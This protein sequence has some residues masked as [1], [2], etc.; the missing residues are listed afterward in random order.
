MDKLLPCVFILLFFHLVARAQSRADWWF[1]GNSATLHFTAGGPESMG[2]GLASMR[3]SA[4]ISDPNGNYLLFTHGGIVRNGTFG[5][6]QNGSFL[7][8][9][10]NNSQSSLFVPHPAS[11]S[12]YF[13]FTVD[14]ANILH[15]S[16]ADITANAG[17]AA[18]LTD[19]FNIP[20][21]PDT[22]ADKITGYSKANGVDY[23][24]VTHVRDSRDFHVYSVTGSGVDP[25]PTV[26]T[27][28][29]V[30]SSDWIS[31]C[32]KVSP[33]GKR[34]AMA[35]AAQDSIDL[36]R[37]D[38]TT[39]GIVYDFSIPLDG[40]DSL[41][42]P[43]GVEFS[44]DGTFLYATTVENIVMQYDLLAGSPQAVINSG[45]EIAQ[46][47]QA[48]LLGG[49]QIAPDE[50][51]YISRYVSFYLPAIEHPSLP[52][53]QAGF[54]PES[55]LCVEM[56]MWGMP[57]FIQSFFVPHIQ[58][59]DACFG[60]T[61]Y[62]STDTAGIDS[63]K[64]DFGDPA[65]G[66]ANTSTLPDAA[67]WYADTGVY[68]VRLVT[69][70]DTFPADAFHYRFR[71][72]P[73]SHM[74]QLPDDTALCGDSLLLGVP[75]SAHFTY[76]WSN[77][78]TG[79]S[80]TVSTPGE[81]WLAVTS[82]C[83][84]FNDTV[85]VTSPGIPAVALPGDTTICSNL[86]LVVTPVVTN[87]HSALW[88]TGDTSL[89]ITVSTEGSYRFIGSNPCGADTDSIVILV[90]QPPAADLLPGDS[91]ICTDEPVV[92]TATGDSVVWNS[93]SG[94]SIYVVD[95]TE[96]VL[97]SVFNECGTASD[98][99]TVVI[100]PAGGVHLGGDTVICDRDSIA[101]Y[102]TWPGATYLWNTGDTTDSIW[103]D[104]ETENYVVTVTVG[105]CS[106]TVS[107][108]V[109]PSHTACP[110]ID[111]SLHYYN[112]FTPNG[113]GI[114]DKFHAW[115]DCDIKAY[116]LSIYNRWG[117]LVHYDSHIHF[118]WDGTINGEPAAEGTY[119]FVIDFVDEVIVDEDRRAYSGSLT[120]I[121]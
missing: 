65:S 89:S 50:R 16:V 121:R 77:G 68:A 118:G 71:L 6:V 7:D 44:I 119:F 111:C 57:N 75:Y 1:Y 52:G 24:V 83:F 90:T 74:L 8:G 28:G 56:S 53:V 72:Y 61:I 36:F 37:F 51:I 31:G 69:W 11:D 4:S 94:D 22:I 93:M 101:L 46:T 29:P 25:N 43:F 17:Q 5:N 91:A 117:V 60:D 20:L 78:D 2:A 88:S 47:G 97:L 45:M 85:A 58:M 10:H 32:M 23:W 95:S 104:A 54:D 70:S 39:G 40:T 110:D 80:I 63:L 3:G 9:N 34:L 82:A 64:W 106:M 114:N 103:T 62:F 116:R 109:E 81:Y 115:S 48:L 55:V 19:S 113:D 59:S 92:L 87:V 120:L 112:V 33:D 79:S 107:R 15:Y 12:L 21:H 67:H 13:V 66:A 49:L 41:K 84:T 99:V 35:R 76:L 73:D 38:I 27:T 102:V 18:I 26:I 105:A 96:T 14:Y 98:S 42:G 30:H 100:V 108:R 86:P